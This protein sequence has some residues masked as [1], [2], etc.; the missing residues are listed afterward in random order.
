[1][2]KMPKTQSGEQNKKSF[3]HYPGGDE[4]F[5]RG[6]NFHYSLYAVNLLNILELTSINRG[7][8]SGNITLYFSLI[9]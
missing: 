2:I 1:M 3:L 8:A 5:K 9:V 4:S 7:V 6:T